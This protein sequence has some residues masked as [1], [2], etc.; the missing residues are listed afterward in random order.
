MPLKTH[1]DE[2]PSLN[3]TSMIDVVFLLIIFF[4][5]GTKFTE[6]ERKIALQVP[7]VNDAGALAPAPEK[8]VVNVYSDGR[9]SLDREMV[10]LE[11]LSARLAQA[12]SEYEGLGVIVRGD[13]D[14]AFQHVAEALNA[15]RQ[16]GIAEMGIS[17]RLARND[18]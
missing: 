1:Q 11:Q 2:A 5:V 18:P 17:V 8:F 10:T 4:M 12:R 6:M 15:C 9:L 16:A 14:G 3:L 7:Q 13:A